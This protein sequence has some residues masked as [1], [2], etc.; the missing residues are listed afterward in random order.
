L[1]LAILECDDR[2]VWEM[3]KG[4]MNLLRVY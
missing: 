3:D 4:W 2:T 1:H